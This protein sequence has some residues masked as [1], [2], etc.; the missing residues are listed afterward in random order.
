M[1][2]WLS[3]VDNYSFQSWQSP[4]KLIQVKIISEA[5]GSFLYLMSLEEACSNC[6]EEMTE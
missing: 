5:T 3:D 2:E 1:V 4:P 6:Q